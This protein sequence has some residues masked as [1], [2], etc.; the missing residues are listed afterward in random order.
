[1]LQYEN[2]GLLNVFLKPVPSSGSQNGTSFDIQKDASVMSTSL[3]HMVMG[4][5]D[6]AD[7][8]VLAA[9][10]EDLG[11]GEAAVKEAIANPNH[12]GQLIV[13]FIV[14]LVFATLG[15]LAI[16][17]CS[18][19]CCCC[20]P[21][22]GHYDSD[23]E[24]EDGPLR[25]PT[26]KDQ[27][28]ICC[29]LH[30]LA[31]VMT[32]LLL[33]GLA[34]S[35]GYYFGAAN[36]LSETLADSQVDDKD[37]IVWLGG[38]SSS[39]S[40]G[41]IMR[42]LVS[43]VGQ[44]GNSSIESAKTSV[45]STVTI[46]K[47]HLL[48]MTLPD[49][50]S[51]L[52]TAVMTEFKVMEI[53]QAVD[54]MVYAVG[55][56]TENSN[57][58]T[59][60]YNSTIKSIM[61][62]SVE[63]EFILNST[64]QNCSADKSEAEAL[65]NHLNPKE[66]L[67]VPSNVTDM[68]NKTNKQLQDLKS[69]LENVTKQLQ[70]KKDDVMKELQDKLDLEKI[71]ESM[72]NLMGN[73]ETE[74]GKVNNQLE[75]M[76][77]KVSGLLGQYSGPA[78]A[79]LYVLCL[80]CL[81]AGILFLIFLIL[82]LFE[83]LQR[84][85]F[86]LTGESA[87]EASGAW[88]SRSRVCGGGMFCIC[89]ALLLLPIILFGLVAV[90]MVTMGGFLDAELCPYIANNSGISKTDYVINSQVKVM[91]DDLIPSQV[92]GGS[93]ATGN[94]LTGLLNLKAPQNLLHA[95]EVGCDPQT[96]GPTSKSGLLVQTGIDNLVNV[97]ALLESPLLTEGIKSANKSLVD[98]IAGAKL[99]DV[100]SNDTIKEIKNFTS[101]FQKLVALLNISNSAKHLQENVFKTEAI[102]TFA[103]KMASN[104]SEQ[105]NK[106]TALVPQ[107]EASNASSAELRNAYVS[108]NNNT[109]ALNSS[110]LESGIASFKSVTATE[111]SVAGAIEKPFEAFVAALL[112][113]VNETGNAAFGNLTHRLLPCGG[114]H[115]A[116]KSVVF[117]GCGPSGLA[118]RLFAWGLFLSLCLFFTF[119]S[120]L[121]L[122]LLW[123]VQN[124]QAK[125]FSDSWSSKDD[126]SMS[127]Y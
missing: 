61:E 88:M 110:K 122:C 98:G 72:N 54:E 125:R 109:L 92:A 79:A 80:P 8:A 47:K 118:S 38:N 107:L 90:V 25:T 116:V 9:L 94:D 105:A 59:K 84:H 20:T 83:A 63:L 27:N 45:N 112:G 95:V 74:F 14:C 101:V 4:K 76:T 114:L 77:N 89:S 127:E 104:C 103:R 82:F 87:S 46:L 67:P 16:F 124:H 113:S 43:N 123:R 73:L 60:N 37:V 99:G 3:M 69:K 81:L 78:K 102:G 7:L 51:T 117:M 44:F 18:L 22:R 40:I 119:F 10:P 11:G 62:K 32:A 34:V 12:E 30:I 97:T 96:A 57:Y 35:I 41:R 49:E 111:T 6:K 56:A 39:F 24:D 26:T 91:W 5:L 13:A 23:E 42:F 2:G 64:M 48:E 19:I 86:S 100:I 58:I 21:S 68:L 33:V 29:S 106:L 70:A 75:G 66:V 28:F 17:V 85:L 115:Y 36:V 31:F 1:M 93:A 71:L 53:W 126:D 108:L 50:I 15:L 52:L 55:N 65:K 120:L 121:S